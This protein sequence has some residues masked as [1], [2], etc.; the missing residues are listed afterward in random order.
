MAGE[1]ARKAHIGGS[2]ILIV[3]FTFPFQAIAIDFLLNVHI[4]TYI[5]HIRFGF[6]KL[7]LPQVVNPTHLIS[8]PRWFSQCE[9]DC[10]QILTQTQLFGAVF[11]P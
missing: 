4:G 3:L 6:R 11:I 2:N 9:C 10:H 7:R 1:L 5:K 8:A